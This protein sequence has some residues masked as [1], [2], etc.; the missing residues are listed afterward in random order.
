[1]IL[2]YFLNV[3]AC[4]CLYV[5][6]C[7]RY[8]RSRIINYIEISMMNGTT[9]PEPMMVVNGGH[10]TLINGYSYSNNDFNESNTT[11]TKSRIV[12]N[13]SPNVHG[14]TPLVGL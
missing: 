13:D 8:F 1:M 7:F 2:A 12:N 9:S 14:N 4:Y 5:C 3:S 11:P 6:V 10:D